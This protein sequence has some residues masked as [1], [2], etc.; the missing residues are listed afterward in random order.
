MKEQSALWIHTAIQQE[1][2]WQLWGLQAEYE[3]GA[4][5]T[6]HLF[7]FHTMANLNQNTITIL[8]ITLEE[9]CRPSVRCPEAG[10]SVMKDHKNT[11]KVRK[12]DWGGVQQSSQRKAA[13]ERVGFVCS[14]QR[15]GLKVLWH[16]WRLKMIYLSQLT[17]GIDCLGRVG[18]MYCW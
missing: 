16:R 10:E 5:R 11:R 18:S 4:P 15:R 12:E 13:S 3:W 8:G 6:R 14:W 1:S 9:R 17:T 7:L 2:L